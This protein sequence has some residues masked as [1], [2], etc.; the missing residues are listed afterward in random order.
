[1]NNI[2]KIVLNVVVQMYALIAM[3]IILERI[4]KD[5]YLIVIMIK[6]L[7]QKLIII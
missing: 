4:I 2:I 5:A 7:M 1:M 3:V 6:N